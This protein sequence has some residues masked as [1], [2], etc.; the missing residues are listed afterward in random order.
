MMLEL[1]QRVDSL[2]TSHFPALF[3][4]VEEDPISRQMRRVPTIQHGQFVLN[5]L[6]WL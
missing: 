6:K 1:E 4:T 5:T 3:S 2:R